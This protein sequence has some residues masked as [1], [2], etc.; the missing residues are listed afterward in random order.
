MCTWFPESAGYFG[1]PGTES[2]RIVRALF[3]YAGAG[4]NFLRAPHRRGLRG[5]RSHYPPHPGLFRY[6]SRGPGAA[7]EFRFQSGRDCRMRPG[8][9]PLRITQPDG[10]EFRVANGEVSWQKWHFRFGMHPRE[11]LVLY[12]VGFEDH[13]RIRPI[14][15][16]VSLSEMLVP[17]G[18]PSGAWFFRN[19]FDAGELGLGVAAVTMRPGVDCPQNCSVF[20]AVL[21]DESGTPRTIPGAVALYERDSGLAWKHGDE[22]RRAR[23]GDRLL[24]R[25]GQ[26]RL[27]L[28]LDLSPGRHDRSA[29]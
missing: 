9:A 29:R 17:Y 11:G 28:R 18:D 13:G 7:P 4:E 10:P 20:D 8:L 12:S 23:T 26:L 24:D 5:G 22:A 16:R 1:L 3:Y 27:R 21:P 15:Y 14:L 6:R 25:G 2:D 19:S